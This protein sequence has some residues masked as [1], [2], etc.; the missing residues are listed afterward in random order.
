VDF[1]TQ[2]KE[3]TMRRKLMHSLAVMTAA[4]G[5]TLAGPGIA[6]AAPPPDA[7][8]AAESDTGVSASGPEGALCTY[9]TSVGD[10]CFKKNGD[11]WYVSDG[12][13]DGNSVYVDWRNELTNSGGNWVSYRS[14]KCWSHLGKDNWA[15]CNKDFWEHGAL[16]AKGGYGSRVE[17]RICIDDLFADTCSSWR[18]PELNNG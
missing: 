1:A 12:H 10:G 11:I 17:W 5:L 14:G 13:A 8:L 16:N 7:E 3:V 6:S 4:L 9:T 2:K 15:K 18:I